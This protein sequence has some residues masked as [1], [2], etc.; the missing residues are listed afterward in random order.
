MDSPWPSDSTD[1]CDED[2]M[3]GGG[4]LPMMI[5]PIDT[6]GGERRRTRYHH[7]EGY[8][9][10]QHRVGSNGR[11]D[12]SAVSPVENAGR[13]EGTERFLSPVPAGASKAAPQSR[14]KSGKAGWR[15]RRMR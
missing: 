4:F 14:K 15:T 1:I 5:P 11:I 2:T 13:R 8:V 12:D 10:T 6:G 9:R 3:T 7:L